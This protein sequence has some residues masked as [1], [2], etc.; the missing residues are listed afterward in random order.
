[1]VAAARQEV[2]IG[3]AKKSDECGDQALREVVCAKHAVVVVAKCIPAQ[4]LQSMKTPAE[5]KNE[6]ELTN[7]HCRSQ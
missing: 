5:K 1:M 7:R 3:A 2:D 6:R 4:Q